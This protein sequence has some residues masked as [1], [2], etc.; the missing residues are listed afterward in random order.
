VAAIT[1]EVYAHLFERANHAD[2]ARAAPDANYST[3]S[4]GGG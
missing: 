2:T 3:I 4:N 1:L